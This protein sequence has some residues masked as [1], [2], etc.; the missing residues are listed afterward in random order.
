MQL[1]RLRQTTWQAN[2]SSR[3]SDVRLLAD[4]CISRSLVAAIRDAGHDVAWITEVESG[5]PDKAVLARAF[6]EGR[7]LLTEDRDFG[8][9]TVRSGHRSHGVIL[10]ALWSMPSEDR[11]ARIVQALNVLAGMPA[12]QFVVI[13]P[14]RLRCRSLVHRPDT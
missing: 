1:R 9:M 5:A 10:M 2:R 6:N 8:E 3:Q 11:A 4:E 13:E 14:Q 7:I 12:N